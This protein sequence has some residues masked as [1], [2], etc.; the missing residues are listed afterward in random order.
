MAEQ[1][2][3]LTCE[4]DGDDGLLVTLSDGTTGG[5]VVEELLKLRPDRGRIKTKLA[6]SEKASVRVQKPS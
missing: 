1:I 2:R 3:I 5:Y 4:R 6:V